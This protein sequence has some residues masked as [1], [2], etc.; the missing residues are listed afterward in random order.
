MAAR[1]PM[2]ETA[3]EGGGGGGRWCVDGDY[4]DAV[5]KVEL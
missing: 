4:E 5:E 3:A 1:M 2:F